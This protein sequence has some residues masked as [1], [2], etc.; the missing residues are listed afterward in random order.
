MA[1]DLSQLV[2]QVVADDDRSS[3]WRSLGR[4]IPRSRD[5]ESGDRFDRLDGVALGQQAVGIV[6]NA[7]ETLAM[8]SA[9]S[10]E[11]LAGVRSTSLW[12]GSRFSANARLL[13]VAGQAPK[14][15]P[16]LLILDPSILDRSQSVRLTAEFSELWRYSSPD[17]PREI[18]DKDLADLALESR[19][20]LSDML[21]ITQPEV[22][23]TRLPEMVPLCAPNPYLRVDC[24]G[25]ESS[26]GVF[27]RDK[28]GT[29]G[30]TTCLHGTGPTGTEVRVGDVDTVV[31]A[32][33]PVQDMVF[34]P[35]PES[36]PR[37]PVYGNRGVRR[38]PAPSESESAKFYGAGSKRLVD[39]RIQGHDAGLQRTGRLLQ[40]KVQTPPDTNSGDSGA[41]LIDDDDRVVAFAFW[42]TAI[43]E[44]PEF[45]DWIWASNAISSL[46]LTPV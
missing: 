6:G 9:L 35:L 46:N 17:A 24:N 32:H 2:E 11:L 20:N 36:F 8:L 4:F 5:L 42:R 10:V 22:V 23:L 25:Q 37:P 19:S 15:T 16:T 21:W 3:P 7:P 1:T 45:T 26:V 44:F 33:D 41:A 13:Y 31:K 34:L 18:A 43:G 30:V 12:N 28:F 29:F 38:W 14:F 40:L 39:T 27:C